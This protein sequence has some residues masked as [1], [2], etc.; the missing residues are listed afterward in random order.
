[1]KLLYVSDIHTEFN[2]QLELPKVDVL[3]L[4]GDIGT[5]KKKTLLL[6]FLKYAAT[7]ATHVIYV[8]GNHDYWGT[9]IDVGSSKIQDLITK[10]KLHN[11]H[12]LDQATYTILDFGRSITF[13]GA[14]LWSQAS[15]A[16]QHEINDYSKIRG[17]SYNKLSASSI[18]AVHSKTSEW[19]NQTLEEIESDVKIVV[20]HH[21]PRLT[22]DCHQDPYSSAYRSDMTEVMER[23]NPDYW[24]YGH[25]HKAD[26]VVIFST[27]VLSNPLGYPGELE[28]SHK[29]LDI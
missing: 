25:T 26:D 6:N 20:T 8:L 11:V 23:H 13:Y 2:V 24:I 5:F 3:V 9:A 19:L 14:T 12:L 27:R 18:R 10:A 7:R 29:I 17:P 15:D 16:I 28:Y 22:H 4:A 1:M 21:M